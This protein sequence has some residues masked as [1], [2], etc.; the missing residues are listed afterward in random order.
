MVLQ[1]G[2][3]QLITRVPDVDDVERG[4]R[5]SVARLRSRARRDDLRVSVRDRDVSL[6]DPMGTIAHCGTLETAWLWIE[7]FDLEGS[8]Q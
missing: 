2:S 1:D 6:I 3:E 8:Q 5:R 4:H 7:G